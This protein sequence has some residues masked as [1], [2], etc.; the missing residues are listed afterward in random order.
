MT[1]A[2]N[3]EIKFYCMEYR[4]QSCPTQVIIFSLEPS[5]TFSR[6]FGIPSKNRQNFGQFIET[7]IE[8]CKRAIFQKS[9]SFSKKTLKQKKYG[10]VKV[11]RKAHLK[12]LRTDFCLTASQRKSNLKHFWTLKQRNEL[13][14][15]GPLATWV[16]NWAIFLWPKKN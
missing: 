5:S 13:F 11:S 14:F 4:I 1:K 15:Y 6:I 2:P 12:F 8:S 16:E 9:F 7:R 3:N 10:S